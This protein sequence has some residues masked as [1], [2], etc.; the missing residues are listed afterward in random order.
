[1]W[2]ADIY[3]DLQWVA[4]RKGV[5]EERRMRLHGARSTSLGIAIEFHFYG[6][7]ER[8]RHVRALLDTEDQQAAETCADMNMQTWVAA[9]ESAVMLQTGHPFHVERLPGT[10][11][12]V[13]TFGQGGAES[14]AA[15]IGLTVHDPVPLDYHQLAYGFSVW[16]RELRHHLFYFRRLVD[17]S[18]PLDVRWLNGYRLLEWNFVGDRAGLPRS[19][20]WRAFVARFNDAFVPLARPRQS[21]VRLLEEARALA[22]HA[23]LDDRSDEERRV[24][25]RNAMERTFRVLEQM[26]MTALNE[27]PARAGHPV[28]FLARA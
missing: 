12:F 16:N 24:H 15:L 4:E 23:G 1:M 26:V 21:A 13:T 19:P 25:P 8:V 18:L 14:S 2:F 3:C 5:L 22:A 9:L 28:R 11:T 17:E 10:T 7:G 20:E 6:D 27:H